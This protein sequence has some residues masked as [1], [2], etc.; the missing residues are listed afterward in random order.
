MESVYSLLIDGTM[1]GASVNTWQNMSGCFLTHNMS[2]YSSSNSLLR[3]KLKLSQHLP[4][5]MVVILKKSL[6]Y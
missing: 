6:H 2:R 3:D 4:S 5:E 1:V